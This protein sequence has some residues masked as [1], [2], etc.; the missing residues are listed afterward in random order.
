MASCQNMRARATDNSVNSAYG[1]EGQRT[2]RSWHSLVAAV[3]AVLLLPSVARSAAA[4]SCPSGPRYSIVRYD[5]DLS[6]L[7]DPVCRKDFWDPLKYIPLNARG[8]WYLSFGGE[9][10]ERYERFHNPLW[11]QQPQSPGGFL[12]QRYLLFAD[13]HLGQNVRIFSELM[14]DFENDRVGGPR[15][16]IDQDQLDFTELCVD[17][18]VDPVG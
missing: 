11:G 18:K 6:Y 9:I 10:R 14:S 16:V 2:S 5:D 8:D 13:L 17:L 1:Q 7:H 12:L 15:P 3:V 4:P